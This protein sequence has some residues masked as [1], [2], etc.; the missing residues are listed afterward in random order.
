MTVGVKI[1]GI[2]D[3]AALDAAMDGGARWV[4]FVFFGPSPRNITPTIAATLAA[5]VPTGGPGRIGLFVKPTDADI[6]HVLGTVTLDG[7]Q[8]YAPEPRA[9][10]IRARFGLPVWRAVGVATR[11][12]LPHDTGLDGL[13]IESRAPAGS[14]RPGGNAV[15]LDWGLTHGWRPPVAWMLAGGLNPDNV[16]QAIMRS[17]APAVDVSSGVE[18]APGV[19]S[20]AL[21]RAFIASAHGAHRT[22]GA[23]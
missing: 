18:S 12:D 9:M 22:S 3:R 11:A 15:C 2:T 19:K 17:D 13:V 6:E 8:V 7:L 21:I 20:P 10:E 5:R 23:T 1:C 14:T 16:A 4:G